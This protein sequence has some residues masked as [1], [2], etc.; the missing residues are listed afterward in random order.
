MRCSVSKP[1][2]VIAG[3]VSGLMLAIV[4]VPLNAQAVAHAIHEEHPYYDAAKE[5]TLNGTVANVVTK[6]S[7]GMMMGA[8][9]LL[10]TGSG[11]LDASLGPWGLAGKGAPSVTVGQEVVVTGIVKT[12][13]NRQIFVVRTIN[14][15]GKL[16]TIRNRHGV[17]VSPQARERAAQKGVSL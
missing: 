12:V 4:A 13:N 11:Q 15:G 14:A 7:E 3:M 10:E 8:H 1:A 2:R 16:Y 6:P 9:L 17:L 5:V